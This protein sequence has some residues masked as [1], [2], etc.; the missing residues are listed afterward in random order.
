MIELRGVTKRYGDVLA[1]EDVTLAAAPGEVLALLGPN[2]SGKTTTLKCLA[3]IVRPTAGQALVGGIDVW[4]KPA[5][6]RALLSYLPQRVSFPGVLTAREVL[7]FYSRLRRL[8]RSR[9]DAVLA[10]ARLSLNGFGPR[11]VGELSGGMVQRLGVAAA[12]LPDA[13][14]LLLDEPTASLDP[15]GTL[16]LRRFLRGLKEEGKTVVFSSHVL[17]DVEAIADRVGIFVAGRLAAV[18]P[19]GALRE[20]LAGGSLEEA[21]LR[22]VAES[23]VR[24]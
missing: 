17:A 3:G 5:R 20:R 1:I 18:E 8:P 23:E 6:A 11:A 22:Y 10:D 4:S 21:Y 19:A 12:I 2:G 15:E 13:P 7:E 16:A 14:V 24:S 9:I